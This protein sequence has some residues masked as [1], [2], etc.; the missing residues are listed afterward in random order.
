MFLICACPSAPQANS[1]PRVE[2]AKAARGNLSR[3]AVTAA[4]LPASDPG[5]GEQ[6]EMRHRQWQETHLVAGKGLGIGLLIHPVAIGARAVSYI[7]QSVSTGPC[8]ALVCG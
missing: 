6:V 7:Q 8:S 4:E 2:K 5:L 3:G 1:V